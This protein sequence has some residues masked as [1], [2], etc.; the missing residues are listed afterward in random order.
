METTDGASAFVTARVEVDDA[1]MDEISYTVAVTLDSELKEASFFNRETRME[2][3][4]DDWSLHGEALMESAQDVAVDKL[5]C[6][7]RRKPAV[8]EAGVRKR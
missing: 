8:K 7:A 1:S 6:W 5:R 4:V 2:H 3:Y